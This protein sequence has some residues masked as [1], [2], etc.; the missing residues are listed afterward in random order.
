MVVNLPLVLKL[1]APAIFWVG[2]VGFIPAVFAFWHQQ[3]DEGLSFAAMSVCALVTAN[4]LRLAGR[5]ARVALT[6][7]DLF[8][9]TVSLWILTALIA[10]LPISMLLPDI[11]YT[12]AVFETASAL[13]TTGATAIDGLDGRPL[14]VLLWRSILQFVGGIGFVVI[15]VAVL[16]SFLLGGLNLFKTESTSFDGQ[17]KLTPHIKTMALALLFW[18]LGTAVVCTG[19]YIISGLDWFL[20]LNAAL[21]TVATGGMMPLDASMNELP[22]AVH[23][24]AIFFM[25]LGSLP[26]LALLSTA[27]GRVGTLFRDEQVRGFIKIIA[28]LTAVLTAS[29]IFY[30]GYD[31]E[32]AF[33]VSLFNVVS[34]LSTTGFALEDFTLWNPFATYIFLIILAVGGCSGSTS[35]GIK[36]FRLQ[37]CFAMFKT[38][39]IKSIHPH[40]VLEPHFNGQQ[41]TSEL[42]RAV[43]TYLVAYVLMLL[44]SSCIATL[45]GLNIT[46]AFT[47]TMTSLSNVGPAMGSQ[48]GPSANFADISGAL[49]LLFAFDMIVGRLEI[50]PV[51][52]CLT[53]FFWRL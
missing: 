50:V 34:I 13:S 39:L 7:R 52:L 18:Y 42:I 49:H 33:R 5:H 20:A 19:C 35:G 3:S 22:P 24:F 30:N 36:V 31:L 21:C 14:S 10:A 27:S 23:Y 51:L 44:V 2:I 46:D 28:V 40:Q 6:I 43:V 25:V 4:I 17:A 11:N 29:L 37:I 1:L 32:R 12:G 9:F 38:Q 48:L 16:P 41:L 53:R 45:L 15:G 47:A 8:V 26:F